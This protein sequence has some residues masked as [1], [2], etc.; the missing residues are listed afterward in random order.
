MGEEGFLARQRYREVAGFR[1]PSPLLSSEAKNL[2]GLA[3]L[4]VKE[5]VSSPLGDKGR[6]VP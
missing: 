3:C 6:G 2:W 4:Q 1:V 5:V